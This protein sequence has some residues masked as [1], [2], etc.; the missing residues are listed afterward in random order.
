MRTTAAVLSALDR[1]GDVTEEQPSLGQL[2]ALVRRE[3]EW[4]WQLDAGN[5]LRFEVGAVELD[6]TVEATRSATGTGGLDLK[7][8]GIGASGELSRASTRGT[9]SNVHVVLTPLDTRRTD[10][11]FEVSAQD[12]EPTPRRPGMPGSTTSPVPLHSEPGTTDT[13]QGSAGDTDASLPSSRT[14]PAETS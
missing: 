8:V 3:L 4:A 9:T 12:T 14:G 6:V 13:G 1:G 7:V 2:I 5:P 10:R 11:R